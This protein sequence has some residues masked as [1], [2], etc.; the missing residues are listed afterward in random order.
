MDEYCQP[1]AIL[2]YKS[3]VSRRALVVLS[4]LSPIWAFWFL[5]Q[6]AFLVRSIFAGGIVAN[7]DLSLLLLFYMGLFGLAVLVIVIALDNKL[8]ITSEGI[9]VPLQYIME[10]AGDRTRKWSDLTAVDFS[11]RRITIKFDSL[12]NVSFDQDGF[13][14]EDLRNLC[15]ALRTNAEKISYKFDEEAHR[16][17]IAGIKVKDSKDGF[18]AV[19]EDDLA[20]RFGTTAYV[21]LEAGAELQNGRLKV[22]GQVMFGGLSAIYVCR[23]SNNADT[24]ILKEAVIPVNCDVRSR[25]KALELFER[26]AHLLTTIRHANIARVLDH[27]I[28]NG[29]NYIVLQHIDGTN[30]RQYVKENGPQSERIIMRWA[31]AI[32]EVLAYLH[33]LDPVIVHRDLTPDNLV[34]DKSGAVKLID[35]GAAN[36]LIGT[37]TGTLVGKQAYIAP[38]QFRGK[39]QPASDVYSLGCS[40]Y[41]FAT[42]KDAEALSQSFLPDDLALKYPAL[43]RLIKDCTELEVVDRN[44]RAG[45]AA[46]IAERTRNFLSQKNISVGKNTAGEH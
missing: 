42:G 8:V 4:V 38:E 16:L 3:S 29:H 41:Y 6:S 11:N 45:T 5:F 13:S 9:R 2:P 23:T 24:V 43:Y 10:M 19:W 21:P 18:T 31:L 40:L 1:K 17:G 30:L 36:E 26:E 25:E 33:A 22:I 20:S 14:Q 27:F 34:L 7:W 32:S 37:A 15:V 46:G 28:E 39:A 12:G 44:E 35:F